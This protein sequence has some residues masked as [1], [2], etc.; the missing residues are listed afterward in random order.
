MNKLI[1]RYPIETFVAFLPLWIVLYIAIQ[2]IA[3]SSSPVR[4]SSGRTP[5]EAVRF[6]VFET[7]KVLLLLTLVVFGVG[8]SA[9]SFPPNA[10]VEF[11]R[12]IPLPLEPPLK[13]AR[14][15]YA[16]LFLFGYSALPRFRVVSCSPRRHIF[17]PRC[18]SH[19][20]RDR[21]GPPVRPLRLGD[22]AVV[23]RHRITDCDFRGVR[24][25]PFEG[26]ALR[27]GVGFSGSPDNAN[28]GGL[29]HRSGIAFR[30]DTMP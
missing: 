1:E 4:T 5:E 12:E 19:D 16:V 3:E 17:V 23:C 29:S 14:H 9:P 28:P 13:H 26:R 7:P 27:R 24:H 22:G 10:H 6:F 21:G 11:S 25:R 30:Q 20:Q 18:S 15:R 2:S 8:S